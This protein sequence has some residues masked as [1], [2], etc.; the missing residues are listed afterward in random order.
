MPAFNCINRESIRRL[1][2][3]HFTDS[4]E[5]EVLRVKAL[6]FRKFENLGDV[7][8]IGI[9]YAAPFDVYPTEIDVFQP[10]LIVVLNANQSTSFSTSFIDVFVDLILRLHYQF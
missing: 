5:V 8:P 1:S 2:R 4:Q 9:F 7:S 3:G 6:K 10:N